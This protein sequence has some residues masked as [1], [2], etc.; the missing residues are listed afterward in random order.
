MPVTAV[1]PGTEPKMMPTMV[2][3]IISARVSGDAIAARPSIKSC[4]YHALLYPI[5]PVGRTI[6]RPYTNR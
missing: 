4:I 6:S 3:K 1:R 2:P 5:M